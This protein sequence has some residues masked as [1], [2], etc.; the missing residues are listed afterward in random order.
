MWMKVGRQRFYDQS[1]Q[2]DLPHGFFDQLRS[3]ATPK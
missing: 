3:N 2:R 1:L